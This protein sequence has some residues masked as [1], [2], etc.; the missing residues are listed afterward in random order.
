MQGWVDVEPVHPQAAI[1]CKYIQEEKELDA[2]RQKDKGIQELA[3]R[4]VAHLSKDCGMK[5]GV[6]LQVTVLI[7]P[8]MDEAMKALLETPLTQHGLA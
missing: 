6:W 2:D 8:L 5:W 7:F 1:R 3:V 4:A